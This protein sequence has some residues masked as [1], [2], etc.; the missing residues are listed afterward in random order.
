MQELSYPLG[1]A[2]LVALYAELASG[3]V[4]HDND[5]GEIEL[6]VRR[7]D[8]IMP[9]AAGRARVAREALGFLEALSQ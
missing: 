9:D 7:C 6:P 1:S 5:A 8:T 4:V 3:L 2:G